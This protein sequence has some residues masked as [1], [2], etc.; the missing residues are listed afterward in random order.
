MDGVGQPI[1]RC[2][3]WLPMLEKRLG[4]Y[5]VCVRCFEGVG[6]AKP[7]SLGFCIILLETWGFP[8]RGPKTANVGGFFI[9][10]SKQGF[11]LA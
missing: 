2:G 8:L 11:I 10:R 5:A 6:E 1:D 9:P 7:G 4:A 3:F